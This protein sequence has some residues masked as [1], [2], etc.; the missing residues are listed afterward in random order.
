MDRQALLEQLVGNI[1]AIHLDH[2]VRVAIDGIDAAGKT[3]LA[4]E[5]AVS[6]RFFGRQVMR[7]SV[8][9]FHNPAHIRYQ[10]GHLSPEGYYHDSF[11]YTCFIND[12]LRPLG[13][14]GDRYYRPAV[15]DFRTDQPVDSV[16]LQAA[17]DAILVCDGIFLLRPELRSYWDYAIFLRVDFATSLRRAEQRDIQ[18]LGTAKQVRLRYNQRYIPG[19]QLYLAEANPEAYTSVV[20]NNNDPQH[21]FIV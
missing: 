20:I 19:Q 7:A 9:G 16:P 2:P 1:N 14:G 5:L 18:L 3:V 8:D 17:Q 13:P 4:N 21:P 12:L 11:D 6:L 10:R 15:F